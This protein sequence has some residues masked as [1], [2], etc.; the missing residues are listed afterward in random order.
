[1]RLM[2]NTPSFWADRIKASGIHLVISLCIATL[3][4]GVVFGVW[5]PYPYRELSG[6]RELFTLVVTV[7]VILGP[8]ITLAIFNRVKAW[9][10]LRRDLMFIGAIQILALTYGL[11]T[12][13]LA[14]PVHLVFE[15]D[16]F[17]VVHAAE[18]PLE[19]LPKVIESVEAMPWTGPTPLSVRGYKNEDEHLEGM[20]ASMMGASRGMRPDFWQPYEKSIPEV[21][22]AAK[23]ATLLKGRFTEKA[24]AID[25]ALNESGRNAENTV[26]LPLVGRNQFWTVFLDPI[27]AQVVAYMPLDPF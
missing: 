9:P 16:R 3:A 7:D 5:Y 22:G 12:V 26:Y 11:W 20:L 24:T 14:R 25:R 1:M 15:G 13:S 2:T 8:L 10:V 6:G 23:P 18:V 21:L 19:F 27:T 4:A 17:R